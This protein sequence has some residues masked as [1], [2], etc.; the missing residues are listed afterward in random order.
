MANDEYIPHLG[1]HEADAVKD[2]VACARN[3]D[4]MGPSRIVV[5][6][7]GEVIPYLNIVC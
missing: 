3:S 2:A 7:V 4:L 5:R 6:A 1:L